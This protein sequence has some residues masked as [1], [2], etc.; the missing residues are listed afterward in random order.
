[1]HWHSNTMP[2]PEEL[3]PN[4]RKYVFQKLLGTWSPQL[5]QFSQKGSFTF[6]DRLNFEK[7][8]EKKPTASIVTKLI[9]SHTGVF[10]YQ[11]RKYVNQENSK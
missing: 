5:N 11:R 6:Y 4:E 2:L 9:T 1:M 3:D 8:I 7:Q 10:T